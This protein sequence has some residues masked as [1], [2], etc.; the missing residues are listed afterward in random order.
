MELNTGLSA[1]GMERTNIKFYTNVVTGQTTDLAM[2]A[3]D[4]QA[5]ERMSISN[6]GT[7][8]V[9]NDLVSKKLKVSDSL[10]GLQW[11]DAAQANTAGHLIIE[12]TADASASAGTVGG[13]LVF[14]QRWTNDTTNA[15]YNTQTAATGVIAGVKESTGVP[16]GGLA[17]YTHPEGNNAIVE[18][19][20]INK[21]GNI[22]IGT[23]NP[24][25][26]LEI[27]NSTV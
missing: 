21:L 7:V 20:R 24:S 8:T 14:A 10:G 17:F 25:Q 3:S 11:Y 27:R 9:N 16:G 22:G 15:F 26:K 1:I 12:D 6:S 5:V 2:T 4:M 23:T 18:R 13:Q 19:M